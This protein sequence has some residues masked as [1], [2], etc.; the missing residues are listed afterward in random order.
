MLYLP[1]DLAADHD[2]IVDLQTFAQCK[3]DLVASD[4]HLDTPWPEESD[5]SRAISH[6][7]SL[8]IFIKTLVLALVHCADPNE[9]LKAALQDSAGTG[10]ESLYRLYC[11][12]LKAQV[13]HNN[14]EFQQMIGVLVAAVLY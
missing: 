1:Y 5:F 2:A 6:V 9:S 11:S 4:W 10:L 8:F 14:S 7:N 12:I 3:F 13:V